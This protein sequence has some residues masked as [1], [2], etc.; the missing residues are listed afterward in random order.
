MVQLNTTPSPSTLLLC[1]RLYLCLFTC[2]FRL[3]SS[4][5]KGI[6]AMAAKREELQLAQRVECVRHMGYINKLRSNHTVLYGA[7]LRA[8]LQVS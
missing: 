2:A 5:P 3:A 1:R 8:L 7:R 4:L 6:L